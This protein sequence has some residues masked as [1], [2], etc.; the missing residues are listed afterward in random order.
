MRPLGVPSFEDRLVQDRLSQILQ[1]IWEAQPIYRHQKHVERI[2]RVEVSLHQAMA[3]Q[4]RWL[5][6]GLAVLGTVFKLADLL[7]A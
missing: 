6:G 2:A 4:K 1:A 3:A 7:I 5:L